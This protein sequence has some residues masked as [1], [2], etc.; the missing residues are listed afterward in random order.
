MAEG[1]AF[2]VVSRLNGKDLCS[3]SGLVAGKGLTTGR[4]GK[5]SLDVGGRFWGGRAQGWS[6]AGGLRG[7]RWQHVVGTI[8]FMTRWAGPEM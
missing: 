5:V 4:H 8:N 1:R 6:G 2:H 3:M 7:S